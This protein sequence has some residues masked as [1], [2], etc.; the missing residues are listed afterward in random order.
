MGSCPN[1]TQALDAPVRG[2][3]V[4]MANLRTERVPCLTHLAGIACRMRVPVRGFGRKR[5]KWVGW[6]MGHHEFRRAYGLSWMSWFCCIHRVC[7]GAPLVAAGLG[8][9]TFTA[10]GSFGRQRTYTM[11]RVAR[12]TLGIMRGI[13]PMR[14]GATA[15]PSHPRGSCPGQ[16]DHHGTPCGTLCPGGQGPLTKMPVTWRPLLPATK[17]RPEISCRVPLRRWTRRRPRQPHHASV[18]PYVPS[19]VHG[20]CGHVRGD[21]RNTRRRGGGRSVSRRSACHS[22]PAADPQPGKQH[23]SLFVCVVPH[24]GFIRHVCIHIYIYI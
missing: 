12:R 24:Q 3:A 21:A 19:F 17:A 18:V 9:Y 4:S 16:A 23:D 15:L 20:V 8:H 14:R 11:R 22:L 7:G 6:L 5:I 10:E 13:T 1:A 2:N